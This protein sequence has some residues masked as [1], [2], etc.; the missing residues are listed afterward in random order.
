MSQKKIDFFSEAWLLKFQEILNKNAAYKD[1]AKDWEGDFV[2][3]IDA[4]GKT[5]KQPLR[6]YIDLWHGDCRKVRMAK[7]DEQAA[8]V[9]SGTLANWRLLL[10]GQ[11]D[12]IK[13]LMQ[14][15]FALKG[16]MGKVMRYTKAAAELVA[17]ATKIPTKFPDEK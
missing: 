1:A 17:T 13:G 9:Y 10:A 8:F 7:P 6:G 14:R 2:F 11:I 12:P 5:I 15:K 4:D 3:Q 16:D